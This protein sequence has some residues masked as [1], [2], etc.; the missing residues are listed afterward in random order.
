[1]IL[2]SKEN[3]TATSDISACD[4]NSNSCFANKEKK[5]RIALQLYLGLCFTQVSEVSAKVSCRKMFLFQFCKF[6][7]E[8]GN[9]GATAPHLKQKYS[10]RS[11]MKLG[12]FVMWRAATLYMPKEI[13]K[14]IL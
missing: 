10:K 1:M 2:Y 9:L 3:K 13:V 5:K 6:T 12:L 14:S 7:R 11:V 8:P 4:F